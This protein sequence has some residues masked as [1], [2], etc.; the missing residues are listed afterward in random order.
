MEG[1]SLGRGSCTARTENI[2]TAPGSSL[3]CGRNSHGPGAK[4]ERGFSRPSFSVLCMPHTFDQAA[5]G[6]GG[7][8]S[9]LQ[10]DHRDT[11]AGPPSFC[12]AVLAHFLGQMSPGTEWGEGI[13]IHDLKLWELSYSQARCLSRY[14]G[15]WL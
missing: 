12:C 15:H 14:P 8:C 10:C 1:S 7:G 9:P 11:I 4:C 6:G 3:H 5:R 13:M 2:S